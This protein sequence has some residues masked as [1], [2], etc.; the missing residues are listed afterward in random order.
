VT[1]LREDQAKAAHKCPSNNFLKQISRDL[2]SNVKNEK[3]PK[4]HPKIPKK[5]AGVTAAEVVP[6]AGARPGGSG[7]RPHPPAHVPVAAAEAR[8]AGPRCR[9]RSRE[10]RRV[11]AR[12][13]RRRHRARSREARRTRT[14]HPDGGGRSPQDG[15]A[16]QGG[17]GRRAASAALGAAAQGG[18][19]RREAS[20]ARVR[21][22]RAGG[23]EAAR[24]FWSRWVS[25]PARERAACAGWRWD[26]GGR[27]EAAD[28]YNMGRGIALKLDR[29]CA[30]PL[31]FM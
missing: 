12:R 30:Q 23:K 27:V 26:G 20:A 11:G 7:R 17:F 19:G 1:D 5:M 25:N 31:I 14:L 16:A 21:G 8:R 22:R 3:S 2:A 18:F 13:A 4:I 24:D 9:A 28:P 6:A 29:S 10:V 15:P